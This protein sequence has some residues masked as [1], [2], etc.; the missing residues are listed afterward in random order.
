VCAVCGCKQL[1]KVS[2]PKV[3]KSRDG[4]FQITVP[5]GWLENALDTVKTDMKAGNPIQEMYVMVLNEEKSNFTDETTL[6]DYTTLVR[7]AMI[8]Q[9]TDP[10]ASTPTELTID[11][12]VARQ[13]SIKGATKNVKIAFLITTIESAEH[14]HQ[15]VTWTLISRIDQN[16]ATLQKVT[17]SFHVLPKAG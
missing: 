6:D 9:V 2:Q 10:E 1:Q 5:A 16:Q 8:E 14:F 17:Q 13:Y 11:G 3:I 7:N 15:I 4:R 12:H